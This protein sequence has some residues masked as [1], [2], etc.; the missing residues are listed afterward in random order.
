ML[1]R[2]P[3]ATLK[4]LTMPILAVLGGRDALFDSRTARQ[5]LEDC[6]LHAEVI[7]LP[8]EGHGLHNMMPEIKRFLNSRVAQQ[9]YETR[10]EA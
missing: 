6:T 8:D 9:T 7:F 2:L 1:P 10:Q 4:T 3:D 5:R